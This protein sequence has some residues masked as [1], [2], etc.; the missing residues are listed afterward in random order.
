M[1]GFLS[2][3]SAGQTLM[4][5]GPP[6]SGKSAL[7]GT[8][9]LSSHPALRSGAQ[10][11]VPAQAGSPGLVQGLVAVHA[12]QM[13]TADVVA[14]IGRQ[15]GMQPQSRATVGQVS[16]LLLAQSDPVILLDALDE[17]TEALGV[18]AD[19]LSPLLRRRRDDG[20]ALTRLII[21][22]R[23]GSRYSELVQALAPLVTD[24]LDLSQVDP[25]ALREDLGDYV[26]L[27]LRTQPAYATAARTSMVDRIADATASRLVAA[28]GSLTHGDQGAGVEVEYGEFLIAGLLARY[29]AQREPLRDNAEV[30]EVVNSLPTTLPG[31]LELDLALRSPDY[32]WLRPLLTTLAYAR[33]GGM[34]SAVIASLAGAFQ[35]RS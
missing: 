10:A 11:T 28:R 18:V 16:E 13:Q 12:R 29:L 27:L 22:A 17:S 2:D 33:G 9:A 14:A 21:G 19:A 26:R 25:D 6:G 20:R 5:T 1:S 3:R 15:L 31:V 35:T 23:S 32:P 34:P 24:R 30:H 7:L 8:V 4:V